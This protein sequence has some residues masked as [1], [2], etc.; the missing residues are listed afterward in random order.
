[1]IADTMHSMPAD[2]LLRGG[3]VYTFDP[4]Q[5]TASAI[6]VREGR[7]L[8]VGEDLD[9]LVAS[10][11]RTIEL[12]GRAVVP[13]FVDAH[14]HFGSFALSLEEADLDAA[15]TLEAG[16]VLLRGAAERLAPG[17]WLQ[18]RGWDRNRWGRL[19]TAT[20]LD[21][22][23]GDRPAAL[24]SH[25]GHSL[26]LSSAAM[27]A[28][29]LDASTQ[30]PPGGVIEHDERGEPSGV[31]FENAQD[32]VDPHIPEPTPA[33]LTRA[34][35]NAQRIA[36]AA[37]LTGLHNL[38]GERSLAAFRELEAAGDLT[39]RVFH[40]V[41]YSQL[42][43]A[44]QLG[45]RTGAGS[46]LL[47]IG[48]VKLFSDGALG[49]RTAYLLEPYE[50]RDDGY[51]GIA[52]LQPEELCAA[53]RLATEAGLDV[54]VHAI[55]DAA[56]RSVLDA[57]EATRRDYPTFAERLVR[58]EH[59]QLVHPDDVPRFAQLGV[60]ASMQPIHAVADWRAAD[61]LWGARARHGYAWRPLLQAGAVLALG[62]DAPVERIEPLLSLHAATTRVGPDGEPA[63]GWYPE[64]A[65]SLTEAIDAYTRGSAA[66]ERASDRRGCLA[67]GYDADLVV[68]APDPFVLEPAALRETRVAMTVVGGRTVFEA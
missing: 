16:L 48:P 22:A 25:D 11:T 21:S 35:A 17:A 45:L 23:I 58:I 12:G 38:E 32:L 67:A 68:L 9:G 4:G 13:G 8:A 42:A 59:A 30:S 40:G 39:L 54:A 14:I 55:G 7:I 53:M 46:D 24:S 28:G 57:V 60:I 33:E 15:A 20:D 64:H 5:P 6:A 65:L 51:R 26:W 49:S 10:G 3:R 34:I 61:A 29:G 44:P 41:A 50:G 37:G 56:V 27:R 62:T 18:G 66:A 2:L 19:P 43:A 52:T 1:M 47:R 63:G 36:A 31:V